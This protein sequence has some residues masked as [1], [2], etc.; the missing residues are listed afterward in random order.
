MVT[1][2]LLV[3]LAAVIVDDCKRVPVCSLLKGA[4]ARERLD[5]AGVCA[6]ACPGQTR[7]GGHGRT[8]LRGTHGCSSDSFDCFISFGCIRAVGRVGKDT[9]GVVKERALLMMSVP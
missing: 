2:P 9:D 8:D 3:L 5:L 7:V 6:S 4:T 1:L